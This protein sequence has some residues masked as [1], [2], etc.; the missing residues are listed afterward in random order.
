MKIGRGPY[1]S[2]DP[3]VTLFHFYA[4]DIDFYAQ[5]D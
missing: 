3:N 1:I 5:L 4:D 2:T